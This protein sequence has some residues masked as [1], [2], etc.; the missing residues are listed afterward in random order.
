MTV[1]AESLVKGLCDR[2]G[3]L[4]GHCVHHKDDLGGLDRC[5][6][7]FQLV[8]QLFVDV[9]AACG[10]EENKVVAVFAGEVN[11]VLCDFD[12]V[13][14]TL[15]EYGDV[16][17]LA[18]YLQLFDCGRTVNVA[19]NEQRTSLLL[20]AEQSGELCAVCRFAGALQTC[21]HDDGRRVRRYGKTGGLAAEQGNQFLVYDFND[22][23]RGRQAFED[24][25]V[26]RL[27]GDSLDE[28]LRDLE[29]DVGLKQRHANL[30]H[31][32]LDVRLGQT[33]LA[34]QVLECR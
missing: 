5:F 32:L 30:A 31:S 11:A 26:R 12:R 13:A 10:I 1:D 34:A 7:V 25:G 33:A 14:L 16:K 15:V 29:V 24:L 8:H 20:F 27:F 18:D 21:H 4:T 17:L 2:Y 19:G 23:L 9:Q 22:L 3:V 6:D 28:I